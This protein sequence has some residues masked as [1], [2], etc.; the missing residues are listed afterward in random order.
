MRASNRGETSF[1]HCGPSSA[2]TISTIPLLSSVSSADPEAFMP[3]LSR[4]K[5]A[6]DARMPDSPVICSENSFRAAESTI[7]PAPADC[8]DCGA[9]VTP[10]A[11]AT[12]WTALSISASA[13]EVLDTAPTGSVARSPPRVLAP[14]RVPRSSSAVTNAAQPSPRPQASCTCCAIWDCFTPAE[15]NSWWIR[16]RTASE[17]TCPKALYRGAALVIVGSS[18]L[19]AASAAPSMLGTPS[20]ALISISS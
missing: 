3:S 8:A 20:S 5:R 9:T 15:P 4:M 13:P 16:S 1:G 2:L 14:S 18:A 19:T 6:A 7:A 10:W 11:A 12:A 17:S